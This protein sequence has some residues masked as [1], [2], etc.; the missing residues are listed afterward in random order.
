MNVD[1]ALTLL[2]ECVRKGDDEAKWMLGL[3]CEY[4]IGTTLDIERALLLYNL[5]CNS[6]LTE[7]NLTSL[8]ESLDK[9]NKYLRMTLST[10]NNIGDEGC[11]M[12]FDVL[13]TNS[14][15]TTLNLHGAIF[16]KTKEQ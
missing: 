10:E 7:L 1:C 9:G 6:A 11:R 15:L 16:I 2:E 8:D 13:K 4:G 5:K 12:V 14:V 3:C